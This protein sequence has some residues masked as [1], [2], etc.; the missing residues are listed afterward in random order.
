MFIWLK[1]IL[2]KEDY[3][4]LKDYNKEYKNMIAYESIMFTNTGVHSYK[5]LTPRKVKNITRVAIYYDVQMDKIKENVKFLHKT[6]V[7]RY[8]IRK[9]SFEGMNSLKILF[10]NYIGCLNLE[11]DNKYNFLHNLPNNIE[12]L[13]VRLAEYMQPDENF[14]IHFNNL[15]IGLKY[16]VFHVGTEINYKLF[17]K[18]KLP[19]SCILC[20]TQSNS[21]IINE[22][23][24]II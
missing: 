4:F 21:L 9:I 18:I 1:E 6:I 22:N 2:D 11:D 7:D 12:I 8:P 23:L 17:K 3:N 14:L 15:P 13:V 24:L 20:C 19:F 10:I 5:D 16:L